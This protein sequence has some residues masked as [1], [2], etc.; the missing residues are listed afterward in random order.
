MPPYIRR[1]G[2]DG[3][4]DEGGAST[5]TELL[6]RGVVTPTISSQH[7]LV[8][9]TPEATTKLNAEIHGNTTTHTD[10]CGT[11]QTETNGDTNY[12]ITIEGVILKSTLE[13]LKDMQPT[14]EPVKLVSDIYTGEVVFDVFTVT[15][16]SDG[17]HGRFTYEG[18]EVDQPVFTFQLQTKQT[19]KK[20]SERGN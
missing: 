6:S 9:I 18:V 12:R 8:E 16:E 7:S 17:D 3:V 10:L 5:A 13:D 15:Q 1:T 19:G 4:D 2:G 14:D 20:K 11:S